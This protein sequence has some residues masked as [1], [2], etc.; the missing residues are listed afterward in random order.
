MIALIGAFWTTHDESR[1]GQHSFDSRQLPHDT[2]FTCVAKRNKV[3]APKTNAGCDDIVG[4]RRRQ[5]LNCTVYCSQAALSAWCLSDSRGL[6]NSSYLADT[7]RKGGKTCARTATT[8][9]D[10]RWSF[11]TVIKKRSIPPY[12]HVHSPWFCIRYL[13]KTVQSFPDSLN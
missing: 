7:T 13:F 12:T 4:G 1:P 6:S 2:W 10:C 11:I 5:T 9:Q 3:R 8:E